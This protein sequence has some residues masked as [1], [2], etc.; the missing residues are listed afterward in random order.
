MSLRSLV[1]DE[2]G[3]ALILALILLVIGGLIMAPLL[4][5]MSTGVIAGGAYE[6]KA[7]ELYAADAG[8]EDAVWK[9]QDGTEVRPPSCITDPTSWNYSISDVNGKSVAVTITYVS[10]VTHT[11][12]IVSTA[13]GD[14]SGTKID[15]YVTGVNKYGDFGDMLKYV[16]VSPNDITI[17]GN[18]VHVTGT[19]NASY[20]TS[21]WPPA[22]ELEEFYG[23]QVESL[24]S[25]PSNTITLGGDTTFGPLYYGGN[26]IFTIQSSTDGAALTLNGTFYIKSR[27]EIGKTGKYMVLKLN[28]KTM[29]IDNNSTSQDALLIGLNCKIE[30]PGAIISIGN[31]EIKPQYTVGSET[32]PVFILSVSGQTY[33]QPGASG[34]NYYGTIAGNVTV[35]VQSGKSVNI[36]YPQSIGWGDSLNFLTGIQKLVYS[37]A[38]WEVKPA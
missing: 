22:S 37:I 35:E 26:D 5:Y 14:G 33:L 32:G 21:N 20:S 9:I 19:Q 13:T 17:L 6:K 38:S 15:A 11:Y 18:N 25:Y 16:L 4:S 8:A 29:F 24:T 34:A 31:M 1:K 2:K 12:H 3:Q 23:D 36:I 10:N 28:G 7:D 27:T 30:G